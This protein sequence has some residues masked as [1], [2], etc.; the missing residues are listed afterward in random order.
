MNDTMCLQDEETQV[1]GL[2]VIEN[3]SGFTLAHARHFDRKSAKLYTSLI[4]VFIDVLKTM[5]WECDNG[6]H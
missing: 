3:Y 4:Q 6:Q 1:S 2:V 5:I